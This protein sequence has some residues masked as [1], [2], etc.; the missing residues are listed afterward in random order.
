MKSNRRSAALALL[1]A[2]AA[3]RLPAAEAPSWRIARG[4]VRVVCPLTVGGSFEAR[5]SSLGGTLELGTVN[6]AT[7][8][9]QVSVE[10]KGLDT[11]IGLRNEHMRDHYLEIGKGPGFD[12]AVLS[13]IQLGDV[14]ADTFQGRTRF[15]GTLLLHGTKKP[16]RGQA[17]IR[18]DGGSARVEAAF[19]VVLADF[20]IEKPRYLGVGVRDEVQVK[21]SL[22]GA[23]ATGSAPAR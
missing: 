10:L 14:T 20:G 15:T 9:G 8:T 6:P 1:F 18:R 2:A 22:T 11:G 23:P 7:L 4:E 21:V 16:V 3:T 13:D 19:P 5:T 12:T 17:E